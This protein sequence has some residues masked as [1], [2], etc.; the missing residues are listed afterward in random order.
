MFDPVAALHTCSGSLGASS[1]VIAAG[2]QSMEDRLFARIWEN[3][4]RRLIYGLSDGID[5]PHA[6]FGHLV[7]L[8]HE[9]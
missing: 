5:P 8:G 7:R 6:L 9:P 2:M 1:F 4:T 3:D